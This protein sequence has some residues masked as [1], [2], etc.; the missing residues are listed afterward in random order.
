MIAST[1][2]VF[3]ADPVVPAGDIADTTDQMVKLSVSRTPVEVL[4]PPRGSL[5]RLLAAAER[6]T[7][8]AEACAPSL[9]DG[10][11]HDAI[12]LLVDVPGEI[13]FQNDLMEYYTNNIWVVA[14]CDERAS[15]PALARLP[16]P[17]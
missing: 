17:R 15:P 1:S 2:C 4:L 3:L 7:A 11:L 10:V 13:L 9:F 16:E 5:A 12:D 14:N 6:E 8:P